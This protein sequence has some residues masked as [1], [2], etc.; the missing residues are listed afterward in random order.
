MDYQLQ[1]PLQCNQKV[2]AQLSAFTQGTE[3]IVFNPNPNELL[4]AMLDTVGDTTA[5]AML[6]NL[7]YLLLQQLCETHK[8]KFVLAGGFA[9]FCCG[10]TTDFSDLDVYMKISES[11]YIQ[12]EKFIN[13]LAGGLREVAVKA[14]QDVKGLNSIDVNFCDV[15]SQVPC[16]PYPNKVFKLLV[17]YQGRILP[18]ADFCIIIGSSVEHQTR[19]GHRL[20][21]IHSRRPLDY[22]V[23]KLYTETTDGLLYYQPMVESIENIFHSFDLHFCK[24]ISIPLRRHVCSMASM[25]VSRNTPW[26]QVC[27]LSMSRQTD[28]NGTRERAMKYASRL[29]PQI[30]YKQV[31]EDV[32]DAT[33]QMAELRDEFAK[34]MVVSES[35]SRATHPGRIKEITCYTLFSFFPNPT[36]FDIMLDRHLL[37]I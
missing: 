3:S 24:S 6:R 8:G 26:E 17:E 31:N 34:G 13:N 23:K 7:Q 11:T 35:V 21:H 18:V 10:K 28:G 27:Q 19:K 20:M 25:N 4:K 30:L 12:E 22:M 15:S 5:G 2:L 29:S 37:A 1:Q 14:W 36:G 33:K 32:G 16:Y 9:T